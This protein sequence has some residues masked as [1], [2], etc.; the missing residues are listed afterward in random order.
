MNLL[1]VV[2][3]GVSIMAMNFSIFLN[4]NLNSPL[5]HTMCGNIKAA[6]TSIIG[7]VVFHKPVSQLG[8]IGLVLNFV[9]GLWYSYVKYAQAERKKAQVHQHV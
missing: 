1:L 3:N 6:T 5:S 4:C 2:I 9:G 8:G 7:H